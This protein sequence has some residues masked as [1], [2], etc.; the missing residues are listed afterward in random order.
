MLGATPKS[1]QAKSCIGV[2]KGFF[3]D[4]LLRMEELTNEGVVE[5]GLPLGMR[6]ISRL[7]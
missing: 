4:T 5:F 7:R 1:G 6:A 3:E 2:E